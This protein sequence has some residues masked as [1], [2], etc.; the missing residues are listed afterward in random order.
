MEHLL[1][2]SEFEGEVRVDDSARDLIPLLLLAIAELRTG[3]F[4]RRSIVD[5]KV[6][7]SGVLDSV[8]EDRW[9][10]LLAELRKWLWEEVMV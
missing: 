1:P 9:K 8:V 5:A 6:E 10:P 4:G 2:G 3:R 7:D